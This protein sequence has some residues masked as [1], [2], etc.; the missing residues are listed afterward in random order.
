M[1]LPLLRLGGTVQENPHMRAFW[2]STFSFFIAF[3]G[4]FALAP[5]AID[6]MHSIGKCENQIYSIEE[7]PTR[8]AYLDYKSVATGERFCVHGKT[9]DGS[10]CKEIPAEADIEV[11]N[12][13]ASSDECTRAKTTKYD[14]ELLGK[15][16][17]VCGKGTECKNI[18][19]NG[20]IA[21]VSSTVFV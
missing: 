20:G 16:K 6:V 9:E 1:E 10:D 2:G 21:S 19:A 14:F 17:C 13:D 7:N 3:V 5:V 15:V 8:P 11:C 18:I 12:E 4:W